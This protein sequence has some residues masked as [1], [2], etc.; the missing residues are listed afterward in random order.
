[1]EWLSALI[2]WVT[3]PVK[4]PSEEADRS[5]LGMDDMPIFG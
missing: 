3:A 5:A 1:M 2:E 4:S